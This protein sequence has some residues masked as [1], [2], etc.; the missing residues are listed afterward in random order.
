MGHLSYVGDSILGESVNFGAG[1][2]TSNLR[3]DG[4]NHRSLVH[5]VLIDTGRRKFGTIVGDG[6]HTGIN[7]TIYPGR[8]FWPGTSTLPGQIVISDVLP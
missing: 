1:T 7:T 8:K 5:G 3:H 4:K 6:V 2:T